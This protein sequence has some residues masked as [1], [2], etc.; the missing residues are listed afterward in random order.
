MIP[1]G[2]LPRA[3]A[4]VGGAFVAGAASWA[5]LQALAPATIEDRVRL[6]GEVTNVVIDTA[7]GDLEIR[8][9][10]D[11]GVEAVSRERSFL[12]G[13]AFAAS[14]DAGAATLRWSCRLWASCRAD[15]RARVPDGVA[16]EARTGLGEVT[17]R[18]AI[19]GADVQ[20][21][22]GDVR[23]NALAG[24]R[25]LVDARRGDVTLVFARAPDEVT[26]D[27]SSGD[28]EVVL[29][30]AAYRVEATSRAGD[31]RLRGVRDDPR[32]TRRIVIETG[33]GDVVVR[34]AG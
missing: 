31:V 25:V 28:V 4:L 5:L 15:V 6:A 29:P 23:A 11:P 34:E 7:Q 20:T 26:V 18:G 21:R 3:A 27:V 10:P 30:P 22:A 8:A 33:A 16:V 1:D 12:L 13:V 32:A 2:R 14:A 9:A 24:G 19:E 17:L